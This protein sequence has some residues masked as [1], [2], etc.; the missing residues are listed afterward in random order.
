MLQIFEPTYNELWSNS[1]HSLHTFAT[2]VLR[3]LINYIGDYIVTVAS[4]V[5]HCFYYNVPL[6]LHDRIS[7]PKL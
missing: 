5:S 6:L 4:C 7:S 1:V 2:V 3:S